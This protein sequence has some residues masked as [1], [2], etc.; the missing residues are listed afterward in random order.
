MD[1]N[2][3]T[4][5]ST[6]LLVLVGY[7]QVLQLIAQKRQS[8]LDYMQEYRRRWI[9]DKEKWAAVIY[10]GRDEGEYYQVIDKQALNR[11]SEQVDLANNYSPTI[12]ALD[13]SKV[14]F[15]M[16]SDV[17][18]RILK[19]QLDVEDIYPIF[20]TEL[21]RHSRPLRILLD[22]NYVSVFF[23]SNKNH[24]KIRGEVQDWLIYHDGIRRRCLILIDLL[25]SEAV[26]LGDLP[27]CDIKS[28]ADAKL[29]S[30]VISRKNVLKE[31]VRLN[32]RT[33]IFYA[34]K[35]AR[36]LRHS[37]YKRR[38]SCIGIDKKRLE[39]MDKE[40]TDRLLRGFR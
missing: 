29:K 11:F 16:L 25:W 35:L 32:G 33:K 9:S 31:C 28:A 10:I 37:E 15:T 5:L 14:V 30:G 18:T 26:R 19:G 36:H 13:S 20:G 23:D 38:Y 39:V 27:P 24:L 4:A 8:Q 12:W 17:C 2:T 34:V 1:S 7:A 40:W 6:V 3:V 21:L 22:A